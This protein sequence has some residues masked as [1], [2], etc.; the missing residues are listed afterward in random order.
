MLPILEKIAKERRPV[1]VVSS[2]QIHGEALATLIVNKLRGI[3]YSCA[4]TMWV[5]SSLD[6]IASIAEATLDDLG[7]ASR[8]IVTEE[9]TLITP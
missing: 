4:V 9:R 8:I 3:L 7:S 5:V 2:H 1:L 6:R